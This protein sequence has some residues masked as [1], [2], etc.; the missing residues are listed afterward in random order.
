MPSRLAAGHSTYDSCPDSAPNRRDAVACVMHGSCHSISGLPIMAIP[1]FG[2]MPSLEI[3]FESVGSKS[4][5][6][7][8]SAFPEWLYRIRPTG[9][10]RLHGGVLQATEESRVSSPSAA[11]IESH[12]VA[13]FIRCSLVLFKWIPFNG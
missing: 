13:R 12:A 2:H 3:P 6:S 9:V 1:F 5:A 7:V 10:D 8:E 4:L 11:E